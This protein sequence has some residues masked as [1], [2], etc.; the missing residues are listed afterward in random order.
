MPV[1]VRQFICRCWLHGS[2]PLDTIV[3][4]RAIRS[5]PLMKQQVDADWF[6]RVKREVEDCRW[7]KRSTACFRYGY[8]C[9]VM[10]SEPKNWD[11]AGIGS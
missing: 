5:D 10:F 1:A 11:Q 2:R 4:R 3:L 6:V 8:I 9:R 7:T